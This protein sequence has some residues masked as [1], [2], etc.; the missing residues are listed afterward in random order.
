MLPNCKSKR[1]T[2]TTCLE[3]LDGYFLEN[4]KCRACN[5]ALAGCASCTSSKVCISCQSNFL[6]LKNNRCTCVSDGN[7]MI[8]NSDGSCKCADGYFMTDYGCQTCQ[9]LIPGCTNCATSNTISNIRVYDFLSGTGQ[10][11]KYLDCALCDYMKYMVPGNSTSKS[12][13]FNCAQKWDGCSQC[14]IY[15]DQCTTC[16]Q[17]H[18]FTNQTHFGYA[19]DSF[20]SN[21]TPATS[22]STITSAA[23]SASLAT[24]GVTCINAVI[25]AIGKGSTDSN[26]LGNYCTT[27]AQA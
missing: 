6:T 13:C 21:P 20:S 4:G 22:S 19:S 26:V 7:N 25:A 16:F 11:K 18:L 5:E 27:V 17:T 9:Y 24:T 1:C 2:S 12:R 8:I 10:S 15:G 14:G 23:L 3:C